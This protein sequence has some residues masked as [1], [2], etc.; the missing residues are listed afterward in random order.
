MRNKAGKKNIGRRDFLRTSLA[1][2]AAAGI[3]SSF[4]YARAAVSPGITITGMYRTQIRGLGGIIVRLETNKGITGY[5]ECRDLDRGSRA[6]LDTFAPHIVGKNPTDIESI[7]NTMMEHYTFPENMANLEQSGTGA[8]SGIET[9]CWDIMGKVNNVPVYKLLGTRL[10]DKIPMYADTDSNQ[11]EDVVSR[12]EKGFK[13]YKCDMYLSRI[14]RGNY[15]TSETPNNFGYR[16][17]TIN[18]AGLDQMHAYM[19]EY[20]NT[21]KSFGEPYASAPVGSDHYQGYNARDQ[22]SVESAIALANTLHDHNPNGYVEDIIDWWIDDCS[23]LPSK[24]VADGTEMGIQTGEDM[25]GFE[26]CKRFSD[27]GAFTNFHPEPNTFGGLNQTLMASKYADSKGVVTYH[28]NSSGP[29]AMASYAH[30]AAV[31]PGFVAM[32]YHQMD[33]LWHDDMID[34]VEKPMIQDGFTFVPEGPGLGVTLNAEQLE[35][36]NASEWTKII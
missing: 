16:E 9:A 22:I 30:L 7:Y 34:G 32:E 3:T 35:A 36:H 18:Q 17:I 8:V 31:T 1:A 25:F 11:H 24:A 5:G 28:H 13:H 20:R 19:E 4:E 15:T 14:A 12:V 26:Q 2:A 29:L 23:G 6:M 27:I 33:R 21:L 10:R